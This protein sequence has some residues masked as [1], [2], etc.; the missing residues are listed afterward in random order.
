MKKRWGGR[1]LNRNRNRNRKLKWSLGEEVCVFVGLCS[2]EEGSTRIAEWLC[3]RTV[4]NQ[5][6]VCISVSYKG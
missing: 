6:V 5:R 2:E 4:I 1:D 3:K